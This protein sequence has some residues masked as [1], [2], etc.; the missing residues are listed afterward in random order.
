MRIGL[1]LANDS[2]VNLALLGR[3]PGCFSLFEYY[4]RCLILYFNLLF[5]V[6]QVW[7]CSMANR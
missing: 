3:Q 4:F 1:S 2:Q 6:A 7:G 5:E